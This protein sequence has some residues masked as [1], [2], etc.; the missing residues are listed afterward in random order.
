MSISSRIDEVIAH[1]TIQSLHIKGEHKEEIITFTHLSIKTWYV[2]F[3]TIDCGKN[4][5]IGHSNETV[6]TYK[7]KYAIS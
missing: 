2:Q 6:F 4:E 3:L 5:T 1:C 7:I